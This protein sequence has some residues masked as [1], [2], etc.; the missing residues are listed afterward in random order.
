MPFPAS[1]KRENFKNKLCTSSHYEMCSIA[2]KKKKFYFITDS[3]LIYIY[4]KYLEFCKNTNHTEEGKTILCS[5]FPKATTVSDI[6]Q[7]LQKVFFMTF[8]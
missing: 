2:K 5:Q 7:Y 4:V 1:K 8:F 6:S 3:E